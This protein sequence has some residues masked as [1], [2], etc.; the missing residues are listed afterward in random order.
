MADINGTLAETL[1]DFTSTATGTT[2]PL[3]SIAVTL[4]D[5]TSTASGLVESG[6]DAFLFLTLD[7]FTLA[8]TGDVPPAGVLAVTLDNFQISV[9]AAIP[10][11]VPNLGN[12]LWLTDVSTKYKYKRGN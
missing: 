6:N 9:T 8:A 2:P 4:S 12:A 10:G 7:D 1:N 3:G 5:F 11:S